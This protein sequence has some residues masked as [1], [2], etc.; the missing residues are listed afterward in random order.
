[1]TDSIELMSAG[2]HGNVAA[3]LPPKSVTPSL[4]GWS[5]GSVPAGAQRKGD[6]I[7]VSEH[8][9]LRLTLDVSSMANRHGEEE[10]LPH[11]ARLYVS[12]EHL[13]GGRWET[14]HAFDPMDARGRQ[15]A[16]LTGFGTSVRASWYFARPGIPH[17]TIT[18]GVA[19]TWSLTGDALPGAA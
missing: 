7:D 9:M 6:V 14:L 10:G 5:G 11:R 17:H 3:V 18:E 13:L 16:V 8:T 2:D 15:S 1:M 19:F 4:A 12:V